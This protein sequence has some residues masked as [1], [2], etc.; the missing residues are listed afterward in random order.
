MIFQLMGSPA[1]SDNLGGPISTNVG[2]TNGL[3][4]LKL[5]FSSVANAFNGQQR[6]LQLTVDGTP[7]SPRQELTPSPYSSYTYN[8]ALAQSV[9]SGS[10]TADSLQANLLANGTRRVE[11]RYNGINATNQFLATDSRPLN[12]REQQAGDAVYRRHRHGQHAAGRKRPGRLGSEQLWSGVIGNHRGRR[13]PK[14]RRW[15]RAQPDQ[16]RLWVLRCAAIIDV[17]L[18]GHRGGPEIFCRAIPARSR[19]VLATMSNRTTA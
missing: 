19:V 14:I 15:R 2:V 7:L 8:A 5:D 12:L 4:S 1:G 9:A 13:L 16:W 18:R 10:I 17:L 3:F 6:W 11:P